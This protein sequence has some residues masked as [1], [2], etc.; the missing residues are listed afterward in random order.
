[1]F[2]SEERLITQLIELYNYPK[3][4]ESKFIEGE[5]ILNLPHIQ[6][7]DTDVFEVSDVIGNREQLFILT[8]YEDVSSQIEATLQ[9]DMI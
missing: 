2:P 8:N 5:A 1:M 6:D 9:K 4:Y 3:I 7:E